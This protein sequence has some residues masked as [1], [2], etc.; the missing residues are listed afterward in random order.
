MDWIFVKDLAGPEAPKMQRTS[1][2]YRATGA[3][4]LKTQPGERWDEE[5]G[6]NGKQYIVTGGGGFGEVLNNAFV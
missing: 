5:K 6:L 1:T 4:V 2:R 3:E